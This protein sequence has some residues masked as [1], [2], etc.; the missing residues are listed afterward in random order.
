MIALVRRLYLSN[1]KAALRHHAP[2]G[3]PKNPRPT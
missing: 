2:R 3:P 1:D